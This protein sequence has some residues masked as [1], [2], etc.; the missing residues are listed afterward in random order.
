MKVRHVDFYADEWLVGTAGLSLEERGLYVTICSLIYSQGGPIREDINELSHR[1][2]CHPRTFAAV[3]K[4]L[5][6]AGKVCR[7]DGEL[8]VNRCRT[9]L[10]KA[11]NRTSKAREHGSKGGRP[12][13]ENSGI[14]KP[15]GLSPGL[16][17]EKLTTNLPTTNLPTKEEESSSPEI[18]VPF[19]AREEPKRYA[20]E[21]KVLKLT[22]KDFDG[23]RTAFHGVLD[24]A[25]R[26][27]PLD[28]GMSMEDPPPTLKQA[29]F[30]GS[31]W[32]SKLHEEA[33][34]QKREQARPITE[35]YPNEGVFRA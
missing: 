4:K 7:S 6:E 16:D 35:R 12:V 22:Q 9:E 13:K 28:D 17:A 34:R 19:P 27:T 14:T 30:R 25:A 1:C 3:L 31:A 20:Y 24:I 8:M 32:L 5:T 18:V 21:G 26:L 10:E 29:F 11:A 33:M 23:W 2:K 15:G